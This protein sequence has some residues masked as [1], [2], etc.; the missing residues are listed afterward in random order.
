MEQNLALRKPGVNQKRTEPNKE[1]A[2][3]VPKSAEV[4]NRQKP[5]QN[6]TTLKG[7]TTTV[8]GIQPTRLPR[9]PDSSGAPRNDTGGVARN[10]SRRIVE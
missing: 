7:R 8:F 5:Q 2:R 6:C 1:K 3:F 4:A 10:D 9:R